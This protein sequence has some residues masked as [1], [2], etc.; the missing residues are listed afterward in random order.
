MINTSSKTSLF[1]SPKKYFISEKS[2]RSGRNY[3]RQAARSTMQTMAR[4]YFTLGS[5][6][7]ICF[8]LKGDIDVY[9]SYYYV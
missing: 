5:Y 9:R 3:I 7:Y 8:S 2:G 6:T 4:S 1:L